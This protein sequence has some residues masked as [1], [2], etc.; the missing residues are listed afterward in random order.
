M[1]AVHV[2]QGIFLPIFF[3]PHCD[4][5]NKMACAPSKDSNQS[6]H[7]PSLIRV[8]AVRLKKARILSYPLSARQRLWSDWA[9]AQA[10]LSLR[11]AHMPFCWFR[12]EAAHFSALS[13]HFSETIDIRLANLSQR[14]LV[15]FWYLSP[16]VNSIF[17]RACAAFHWG[18]TSDVWSDPLSNSIR[19]VCEQRRLLRDYADAQARLRLRWSPMR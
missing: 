5:T 19:Y 17:K 3:E 13:G 11:W 15:R 6:W 2:Q 4:T 9:D 7:P 8:F 14:R 1:M 18:Y 16:S 12:H 10:D